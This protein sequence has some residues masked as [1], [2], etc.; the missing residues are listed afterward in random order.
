MMLKR[1]FITFVL[2]N[3]LE[4]HH[5]KL[6]SNYLDTASVQG[7]KNTP[8]GRWEDIINTILFC[9]NINIMLLL[10]MVLLLSHLS[11]CLSVCRI[12]QKVADGSG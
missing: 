2:R 3:G 4:K 7:G 9:N 8:W 5:D 6:I 1:T 11:V 12:S 10:S